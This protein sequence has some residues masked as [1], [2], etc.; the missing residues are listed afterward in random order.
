M[1]IKY[2]EFIKKPG[3]E[4]EYSADMIRELQRCQEDIWNFLPYIKII[5]PDKGIIVFEPYDFQK[6]I[7]RNLQDNRFNVILA[8][9][10]SGKTTTISAYVLWYACFNADKTIGI[11][12]NKQV[13]AIDIMN[14]IKRVYQELPVWMKPGITEWSKTFITFDNGTRIMV[15]ATSE[16]AFRGRTLNLLCMDEFAFVPKFVADAFW[17]ANYPT[18]SASTD[19]KIVIVSTPHGMFN[20]FHTLYSNAERGENNFKHFKSTWKDVPGRDDEW[21]EAQRKNLGNKKFAQEYACVDGK[22]LI[23]VFDK[24]T[25][26]EKTIKIEDLY[27]I[28]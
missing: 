24:I 16:D 28:L 21:A 20:S 6:Q 1:G 5:H 10:Q 17:A 23:K 14:R 18:I 26:E 12:S 8:S 25:K 19:A 22:T 9:R 11:V 15:S 2:S 27:N 7:L 13:S 3:E 4:L